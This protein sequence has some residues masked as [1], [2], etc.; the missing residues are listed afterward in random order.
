M[1]NTDRIENMNKWLNNQFQSS[2]STTQE[3]KSF[4]R[5]FNKYLVKELGTD[6][7]VVDFSRGHFYVSGFIQNK[8]GQYIYFSTS[9]VRFFPN[10]WYDN[11][12]IRTAKDVKDY[13]GGANKRTTLK[14][15]KE[16]IER[17][18]S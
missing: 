3:F 16:S 14:N 8:Q 5:D 11:V 15:I 12:L 9:D 1:Y 7:K 18:L 4:A 6:Y 13:S 10:E 17:L 2:S